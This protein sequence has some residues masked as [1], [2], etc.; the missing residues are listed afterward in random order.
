MES[1][2]SHGGSGAA[3]VWL[4]PLVSEAYL[5]DELAASAAGN[6]W[7]AGLLRALHEEGHSLRAIAGAPR[8]AWPRGR[9]VA[10][11]GG[12]TRL[13]AGLSAETLGYLNLPLVKLFRQQARL[14]RVLAEGLRRRERP[15]VVFSYNAGYPEAA[16]AQWLQSTEGVPWVCVV[17]DYPESTDPRVPAVRRA[18]LD[19]YSRFQQQWIDN[20]AGRIFLSWGLFERERKGPKFHLDGGVAAVRGAGEPPDGSKR[21]IIYT[22]SLSAYAGVDLLLDAFSRVRERSCELW[23]CGRGNLEGQ[24]RQAALNDPRIRAFGLVSRERLDELMGQAHVFVNPRPSAVPENRANFPSKL[25][26]YLS[27]CRPVISTITPGIAPAYRPFLSVVDDETPQ[28]LADVMDRSLAIS[29][30]EAANTG[31]RIRSFV[32]GHLLWSV[33]VRRLWQWLETECGVD[34]KHSAANGR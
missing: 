29:A 28:G 11:G 15:S 9:L 14:R 32:E 4:G 18:A 25:L 12:T 16:T 3:G 34:P 23:I 17:A 7:Q 19:I 8:A 6:E 31:A 2:Q 13:A 33:Q 21:V 26:E 22:G 20:A 1:H 24:V 27:W 10:R 5:K 30:A